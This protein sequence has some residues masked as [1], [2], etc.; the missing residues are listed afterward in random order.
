ML[1]NY[2]YLII[3]S[4]KSFLLIIYNFL[5]NRRYIVGYYNLIRTHYQQTFE[6]ITELVFMQKIKKKIK[7]I[8]IN[9]NDIKFA[10]NKSLSK[11]TRYNYFILQTLT[12]FNIS[13]I[14]IKYSKIKSVPMFSFKNTMIFNDNKC[15][16]YIFNYLK[17]NP[18]TF[19]FD[20]ENFIQV[21][22]WLKNKNINEK[23]LIALTLRTKEDASDR[24]SNLEHWIKFYEYL[25]SK[26]FHPVFIPDLEGPHEF[27]DNSKY[28]FCLPAS[29]N[30]IFRLHLMKLSKLNV[31]VNT[32][33]T[34]PALFFE[35]NYIFVKPISKS[36]TVVDD[37]VSKESLLRQGF[38]INKDIEYLDDSYFRKIL[39]KEDTFENMK[40]VF[41]EF[42]KNLTY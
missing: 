41:E 35:N 40:E 22:Q 20:S 15:C 16:K 5:F 32:G 31:F 6:F 37:W 7:L 4:I 36:K 1:K 26:N 33:P 18:S 28:N 2:K 12:F 14:N 10:S 24:N 8:I 34:V 21:K 42:E 11:M 25:V 3:P 19:E 30:F 9:N 17:K 23:K 29:Y 39:W 13:N 27:L 38:K